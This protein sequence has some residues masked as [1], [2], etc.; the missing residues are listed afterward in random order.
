MPTARSIAIVIATYNGSLFIKEQINSILN[1]TYRDFK[2]YIS[3]DRSSDNTLDIIRNITDERIVIVDNERNLGVVGNFNNVLLSTKE[4]IV[5]LS[6][7][8]DLWPPERLEKMLLFCEENLIEGTPFLTFTDMTLID[9][10]G[11]I[12]S[13]SFYNDVAI[14]PTYN[15]DLRYLTWRCTAYGCTMMFNRALLDLSLPIPDKKDTT[16]HDNWLI[17]CAL[18]KGNVFYYDYKSVFYRQHAFNHTG[19]GRNSL[20][21]KLKNLKKQLTV[22][23]DTQKKRLSQLKVLVDRGILNKNDL[24]KFNSVFDYITSDIV[25]FK[26]ERKVYK[27]VYCFNFI[28]KR[29]L[30]DSILSK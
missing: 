27:I 9:G 13:E 24:N 6:D 15:M 23:D 7:Q 25:P 11:D 20:F 5:F 19:G 26:K 2:L 4:D 21:F 8:D 10:N 16:M 18:T 29:R 3:D 17:L 30:K 28:L 14:E 22:I 1:Q 12:L